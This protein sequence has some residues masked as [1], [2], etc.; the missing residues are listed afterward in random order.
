M[1]AAEENGKCKCAEPPLNMTSWW[2][3]DELSGITAFDSIPFAN[4]G[5]HVNGPTILPV[6]M[7]DAALS[8]DGLDDYVEVP[9]ASNNTL[10]LAIGN[11]DR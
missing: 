6:G 5:T 9:D 4:N 8:F 1:W 7:V 11:F 3:F 2:R 10:D